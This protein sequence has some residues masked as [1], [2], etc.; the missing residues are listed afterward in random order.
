MSVCEQISMNQFLM[1]KTFTLPTYGHIFVVCEG[2]SH[3][4][5]RWIQLTLQVKMNQSQSQRSAPNDR[6]VAEDRSFWTDGFANSEA[7][8]QSGTSSSKG[9]DEMEKHEP[10]VQIISRE[11][12]GTSSHDTDGASA[13][14][15][16]HRPWRTTF[17]RLAPLA[18]ISCMLIAI[19]SII[20]AL[21][22][23]IGCQ[24]AP[25]DD[26]KA[27]PS[28][29]LAICTAIANQAVRFAAFQGLA[30]S[31]WFNALRGSSLA[32]LHRRWR[33]GMTVGGAV[34]AGRNMGLVGLAC[35]FSTLVAIDA[36]LL[37]KAIT[38]VPAPIVDQ[39]VTLEVNLAHQIPTDF[40][41]GWYHASSRWSWAFNDTIPTWNDSI[42]NRLYPEATTNTMYGI[43]WYK[44]AP[45]SGI[46]RGCDKKCKAKVKAP[47]LAT[48]SCT[49]KSMPVN[50][51]EPVDIHTEYSNVPWAA[52]LDHYGFLID[53]SLILGEHESIN[54]ITGYQQSKACSGIFNYTICTLESAVGEYDVEL[55]GDTLSLAPGPPTIIALANNTRV[56]HEWD[57]AKQWNPS[58]LA[59]IVSYAYL[60]YSVI[61][62][63]FEEHGVIQ[64]AAYGTNK[65]QQFV[66]TTALSSKCPGFVDPREYMLRDLNKLMF[67]AGAT[68][69]R[70]SNTSYL[71]SHMDSGLPV[72]TTIIGSKEG[73]QNIF[74]TNLH[75]FGG[76]AVVELICIALILP[77]Y[78]GW[79]K[80]G[81]PVS[82]SP[83]E[84]AKVRLK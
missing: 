33:A 62:S 37:Q 58:T 26:W 16:E 59:G 8:P 41:G 9:N 44:D 39:P 3:L 57:Q 72:K 40:T 53:T 28:A 71:Q 67:L 25:V 65:F 22:I 13:I 34:V 54:L 35:L 49:T 43:E 84:T 61:V 70:Q 29:Y 51:S 36:P 76:A 46:V 83:L 1:F 38:V 69:A 82:F 48:T 79:W 21:G 23:L 31:W 20:A 30:I 64:E 63:Y 12:R 80:L 50:Y 32:Q 24:D 45:L 73:S 56:N 66:D 11:A 60:K 14:Q 7:K 15:H 2:F 42:S 6:A 55:D 5:T 4:I 27:Q 77:T 52:P 17:L 75:W 18:G 19:G 78:F 68:V 81:R 47:A 10:D 74:H